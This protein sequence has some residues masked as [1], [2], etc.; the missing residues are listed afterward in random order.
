MKKRIGLGFALLAMVLIA[1]PLFAT[2]QKEAVND[3]EPVEITIYMPGSGAQADQEMVLEEI[4]A[5]AG[6]KIGAYPNIEFIGWGEWDD[7]KNLMIASGEDFDIAFTA[8]WSNFEQEVSR[9]AWLALND[10]ID[11]NAPSLRENVGRFLNAPVIDG[12]IYAVPTVKEG[13]EGNAFLYNAKYV[14]KY[15]IPIKDIK[16]PKELEPWLALIKEKEPDVVP[17]LVVKD[18]VSDLPRTMMSNWDKLAK[19]FSRHDGVVMHDWQNDKKWDWSATMYDWFN[20]GY[21]QPEAVDLKDPNDTKYWN[22]GNWFAFSHVAHPGKAGEL[23]NQHGYSIVAGAN[24]HQPMVTK[25]IHLG[26]MMA[27]SQSSKH[28]VEAIKVLD[29]MN[30][31]KYFNNLINFGLEGVHYDFVDQEKGIIELLSDGYRPSMGWALQNQFLNYIT[32]K[33]DPNKWAKYEEFNVSA[34][35]YDSVGFFPDMN[36]VKTE[37]ASIS[38]VLET[39]ERML[40][41]G[42]IDPNS[43]KDEFQEAL[44]NAGVEAVATELQNQIDSYLSSK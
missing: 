16:T 21:F 37:M 36:P 39:Y 28:P 34:D 33:E 19:G 25:D 26:S 6:E 38:N 7:K 15:N 27:I 23:S 32:A 14:E 8:S 22:N 41:R 13:A 30:R 2:G 24:L 17:Y 3:G 1:S 31:D 11:E 9:N 43:I 20:A 12:N 42:V 40:D 5:Y 44:I 10:L 4:K 18:R 35:V 29:L